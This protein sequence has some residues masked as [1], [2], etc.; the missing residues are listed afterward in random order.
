MSSILSPQVVQ[1]QASKEI[2]SIRNLTKTFD[3]KT[4]AVDNISFSVFEGEIF[5]F[6]GPNGAG[7]STAINML[8]TILRPTSGDA[9]VCGYDLI[10]D[11]A[12]VRRSIGVVPQDST[13]DDDLTGLEN[14]LLCADFYG[15]PRKI[16]KPRA[17]EL[18]QLVELDKD[19]KRK[20]STYSGGMRRRLE[21]AAGLISRPKLLFL[22]EPTLGLDV[23][24]RAAVWEYIIRLKEEFHMTLFMTTHYLDEA[25]HLCDRI[26]LIDH[27]KIL[28]IGSPKELKESIGGDII[29]IEVQDGTTDLSS[30]IT[31]VQHVLDVR[32]TNSKYRIKAELGEQTAPAVLEAM[33]LG[34]GKVVSISIV[35]P[36]L[37]QAYLE[38]TGRSIREEHAEPG[39]QMPRHGR[40]SMRRRR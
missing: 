22:D 20:V 27:G 18:L 8:T 29:E 1:E 5:G 2:L 38:Y 39:S 16:S 35:K 28:K 11:Q 13:A 37:D 23:Q 3:G 24:T 30:A 7:K 15:I 25:D 14:V 17:W 12:N 4:N 32:K 19:A 34:G 6:L 10:K 21:L 33:R 31:S 36:S 9:I 40:M 26:A